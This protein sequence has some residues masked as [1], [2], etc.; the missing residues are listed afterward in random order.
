M[1]HVNCDNSCVNRAVC[2]PFIVQSQTQ[3]GDMKSFAH[4]EREKKRARGELMLFVKLHL[5]ERFK[6]ILIL[7]YFILFYFNKEI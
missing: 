7:F 2:S 1:L 3:C 6:I 4:F 5:T